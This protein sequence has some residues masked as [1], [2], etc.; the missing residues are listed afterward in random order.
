MKNYWHHRRDWYSPN[1]TDL[2]QLHTGTAAANAA[3]ERCILGQK[4]VVRCC[5]VA[6]AIPIT[7]IQG[8]SRGNSRSGEDRGTTGLACA[9]GRAVADALAQ[10]DAEHGVGV[11]PGALEDARGDVHDAAAQ[12][13]V[14]EGA[15]GGPG[16]RV[17]RGQRGRVTSVLGVGVERAG[18]VQG[19]GG[20]LVAGRESTVHSHG[21]ACLPAARDRK[22]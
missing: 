15:G 13:V 7:G 21:E 19:R 12:G 11:L 8:A 14:G 20:G 1:D 17:P 4:F 16:M 3:E 9:R 10:V 18:R 5:I 22:K 6:K 2:H